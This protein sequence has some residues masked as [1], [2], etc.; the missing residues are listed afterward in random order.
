MITRLPLQIVD[1][2]CC[3]INRTP[4]FEDTYVFRCEELSSSRLDRHMKTQKHRHIELDW[5]SEG[6]ES[7]KCTDEAS[8][9]TEYEK[10]LRYQKLIMRRS[11]PL[12]TP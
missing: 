5:S 9:G 11:L 3:L 4:G 2:I 6:H 8:K 12:K 10:C 1:G 7:P